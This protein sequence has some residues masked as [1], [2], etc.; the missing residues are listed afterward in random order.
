MAKFLVQALAKQGFEGHF[1]AGRMWP[2]SAPTE[3]EV[4]DSE[5]D[6]KPDPSKGIVLGT[7]SFKAVSNDPF[8]NV[9][10]PGDPLDAAKEASQAPVLRERIK[11]LEAENQ[12]L[13]AE[14]ASS[15]GEGAEHEK[16]GRR[17]GERGGG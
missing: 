11:Q 10:A 12:R 5:E 8:I 3:V 9:R 16:R 2:S 15:R 7:R 13:Q 17:G 4:V 14:L 1:R 6:P